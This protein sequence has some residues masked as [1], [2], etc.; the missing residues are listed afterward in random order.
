M[1]QEG[2]WMSPLKPRCSGLV[3]SGNSL[4]HFLLCFCNLFYAFVCILHTNTRPESWFA[5]VTS[6]HFLILLQR[7]YH[8][9]HAAQGSSEGHCLQLLLVL[10]DAGLSTSDAAVRDSEKWL[11][12]PSIRFRTFPARKIMQTNGNIY[13][14]NANVWLPDSMAKIPLWAV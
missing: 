5:W 6:C 7:K 8:E 1:V 2:V 4:Q 3:L 13:C 11:K 14:G 10:L 12:W 9:W